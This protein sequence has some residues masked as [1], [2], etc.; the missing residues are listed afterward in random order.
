[1]GIEEQ[2]EREGIK[3]RLIILTLNR[4]RAGSTMD[5]FMPIIK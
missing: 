3:T 1:M 4:L 5:D 2:L